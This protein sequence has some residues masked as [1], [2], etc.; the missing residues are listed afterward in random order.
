MSC[1]LQITACSSYG[2]PSKHFLFINSHNTHSSLIRGAYALLTLNVDFCF[3]FFFLIMESCLHVTGSKGLPQL[4]VTFTWQRKETLGGLIIN[5]IYIYIL[6]LIYIIFIYLSPLAHTL[7]CYCSL[8]HLSHLL[9]FILVYI[10]TKM[11]TGLKLQSP[12]TNSE[13]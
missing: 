5:F 8:V 1:T 13:K 7:G 4:P 10:V 3:F 6:F 9:S 2:N 12:K 11:V